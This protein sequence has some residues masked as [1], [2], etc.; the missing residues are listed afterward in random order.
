M[1]SFTSLES[2]AE[3]SEKPALEPESDTKLMVTSIE[4]LQNQSVDM[5]SLD[6]INPELLGDRQESTSFSLPEDPFADVQSNVSQSPI[7][8]SQ[9]TNDVQLDDYNPFDL[10]K[11]M[12]ET[13]TPTIPTST[14]KRGFKVIN[15]EPAILNNTVAQEQ[16]Q[17]LGLRKAA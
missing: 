1:E 11:Q 8:D 6:G 15:M 2:K 14:K 17:S 3:H 10:I 9:R 5:D 4:P 12:N 16:S 7:E 13:A